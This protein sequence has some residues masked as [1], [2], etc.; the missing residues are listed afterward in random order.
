MFDTFSIAINGINAAVSRATQSAS[1][2]ANGSL[3]GKNLAEDLVNVQIATVDV[4]ANAAVIKSQ[5]K[6]HKAL[7][8]I[9]V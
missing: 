4:A 9:K 7:L 3:T 8:D 6:M 1:N 5:A 2:I